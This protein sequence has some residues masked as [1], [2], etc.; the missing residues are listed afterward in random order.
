MA[1]L[2]KKAIVEL[3]AEKLEV[4]KKQAGE[5]VDAVLEESIKTL[6]KGDKID[7]P[8]FGK[9]QVKVSK[10]RKGINPLTKEEI[11][12]PAKKAPKFRAAKALKEACK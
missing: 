3:L 5:A 7:I 9:F 4:S 8:G 10:A 2:N 12:I 1:D 11:N 6:K